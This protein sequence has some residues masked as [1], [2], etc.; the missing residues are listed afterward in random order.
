M[1][2]KI[3]NALRAKSGR[4]AVNYLTELSPDELRQEYIAEIPESILGSEFL[5]KYHT[6]DDPVT[7][8][9]P[10]ATYRVAGPTRHPVEENVRVLRFMDALREA[11][12]GDESALL[13]AG[14]MMFGAHESYRD[15]CQLSVPE[16]DFL[17]EA[18]RK[19]GPKSGLVWSQNHGRRHGRHGGRVRQSRGA[20]K[21]HSGNRGGVLAPASA[22]CRI[23]SKA[24]RPAPPNSEPGGYSFTSQGWK[25]TGA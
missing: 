10:D 4:A 25:A 14:E 20:Q 8:I 9:Q 3:I 22:P 11:K 24:P 23:F 21:T 2:K 16:V 5:S 19:R 18:V 17:V 15:N 6:H 1:G 7:T 13:T 12:S